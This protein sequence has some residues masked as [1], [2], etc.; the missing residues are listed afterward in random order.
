VVRATAILLA[1]AAGCTGEIDQGEQVA[2]LS[3]QEQLAQTAW[4]KKALPALHAGTC[5][6]CHAGQMTMGAPSYLAGDKD[7][8]KRDTMVTFVPSVVSLGSPKT[9]PVVL[10]GMHEGPMLSAGQISD[11]LVWIGYEGGA[12]NGGDM[13]IETAHTPVADC[14]T[15]SPPDATCLVTTLDL[16]AAGS[17]GSTITLY[18][19]AL[20]TDLY[21]M[22]LE[23]TAG[24]SGCHLVHPIFRSWPTA[25]PMEPKPDAADTFF[26]VAL[27]LPAGMKATLKDTVTFAGFSAADPISIKFDVLSVK[28]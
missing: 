13:E 17:A 12:R 11:I 19:K 4:I 14:S 8:D 18:G 16:S 25:T 10:K 26:N 2:N 3:P 7:L 20:G 5:D 24:P 28:Q 6:T 9:S 23:V 21:V 1:V 27:D 15:G 22:Q